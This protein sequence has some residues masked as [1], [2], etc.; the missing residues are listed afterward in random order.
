M[1]KILATMLLMLTVLS[2]T[3]QDNKDQVLNEKYFNAKVSEL[4]YR[5]DMTD[6][7]KTKFVPIYRRY[8]EEMRTVMGH[9]KKHK[10]MTD[11]ERLALTKQRME[12]QQQAQAI[13]LKYV[14]EFATVLSARQVSKFFEV[15]SKIQ[16][17]LM[18]RRQHPQKG[19]GRGKQREREKKDRD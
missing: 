13:R 19:K 7:Q 11:A 9:R 6:E 18:Q 1:K 16:K 3:A 14:D 4:V 17:K 2:A 10:Q 15:E 12:R 5:L 8:C